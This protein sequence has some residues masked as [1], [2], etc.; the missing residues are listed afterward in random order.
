MKKFLA[1][2]FAMIT[3][4]GFSACGTEQEPPVEEVIVPEEEIVP[5]EVCYSL[6]DTVKTESIEF[7]LDE[8]DFYKCL[9]NVGDENCYNPVAEYDESAWL[10]YRSSNQYNADDDH[11]IVRI[12]FTYKN[13]GKTAIDNISGIESGHFF[14]EYGDGYSFG[15]F[16]TATKNSDG[17]YAYGFEIEPLSDAVNGRGALKVPIAVMEN[18]EEQLI[19]AVQL[20]GQEFKYKIR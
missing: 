10:Y 2:I 17:D 9:S 1:I 18:T 15:S 14:I 19:L 8:F 4:L 7:T 11:I 20:E 3:V 6:G 13:I 12:S 5:E 16:S